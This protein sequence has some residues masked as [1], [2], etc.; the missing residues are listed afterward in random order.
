MSEKKPEIH[1]MEEMLITT[2]K[3]DVDELARRFCTN[4]ENQPAAY[5]MRKFADL[6]LAADFSTIFIGRLA[7]TELVEVPQL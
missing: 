1:R 3:A 6:F 4:P 5:D 7:T 2:M